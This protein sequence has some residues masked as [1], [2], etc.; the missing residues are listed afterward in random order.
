MRSY[1]T[2][3][4]AAMTAACLL[5]GCGAEILT[6]AAT[7]AELQKQAAQGAT[8]H[9]QQAGANTGR[10]QAERAIQTYHA[11]K[12]KYPTSLEALVPNYIAGVPTRADGSPLGYDPATGQLTEGGAAAAGPQA[13]DLRNLERIRQAINQYGQATGYYPGALQALVPLYLPEIPRT[14]NGQDFLYNPANGELRMPGA[15][16]AGAA[17]NRGAGAA[18]NRGAGGSGLGPMGEAM[19]GVGIQQQLGNTSNA[20]SS[21]AGGAGRRGINNATSQQNQQA[22]EALG[23]LE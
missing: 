7:Q 9:L 3:C 21:A 13:D 11:E 8:R 22:Q 5:A 12:G 14:A 6:V 19:T 1:G 4:A 15:A 20:G 2:F 17:G 18:G 23:Y 10:I 16:G